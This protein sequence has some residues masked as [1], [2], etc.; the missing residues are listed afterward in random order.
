MKKL[1]ICLNRPDARNFFQEFQRQNKEWFSKEENY[2]FKIVE[3]C[4]EC[5]NEFGDYRDVIIIAAPD[6]SILDT[7]KKS[8]NSESKTIILFEIANLYDMVRTFF[9]FGRVIAKLEHL[10]PNVYSFSN[11]A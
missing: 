2:E 10:Y 1:I 7:I 11:L 5:C 8:T 9:N 4:K 6:A 3:N